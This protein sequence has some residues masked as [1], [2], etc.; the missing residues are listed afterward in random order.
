M[1]YTVTYNPNNGDN[2]FSLKVLDNHLT[3]RPEEPIKLGYDF[4]GWYTEYDEQ[5]NFL[6]H[7]VKQDI[8]L[9]AKWSA[10]KYTINLNDDGKISKLDVIYNG[11]YTLP[12]PQKQGYRFLYWVD[13]DGNEVS[14]GIYEKVKDSTL[15]A[16]YRSLYLISF[17]TNGGNQIDDYEIHQENEK[18]NELPIPKKDN[19]TFLGWYYN[20]ENVKAPLIYSY[21][22]DITLTA[23]W[24]LIDGDYEIKDIDENTT[25]V[26]AYLGIDENIEIPSIL[27]N[28]EVKKI[29]KNAFYN[30][31]IVKSI[32]IPESVTSI[33]DYAF[34][35]CSSLLSITIPK[36]V[37]SIGSYAFYDCSSLTSIEIPENVISIGKSAFN[38]C[39]SL[40]NFK[41][42]SS[43]T[44]IESA[45][46]ASCSSLSSIEIPESVTSIGFGAFIRCS[47][48]TNFKIP[49]SITK[50]ER[51]AFAFCNGLTSII[52]PESVISIE[53]DVFLRC[54]SLTIVFCE[55]SAPYDYD[56]KDIS[57]YYANEWEYVD[58]V[59]TPIN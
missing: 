16:I 31:K 47:S 24:A 14:S 57:V 27:N 25:A 5:W 22:T 8:T 13:E 52:I 7:V 1:Y 12:T 9:T 18:I 26:I 48:L 23:K 11:S 54:N 55:T 30:N 29:N 45:T 40:T 35:R 2:N 38:R 51:A 43:I 39:S 15:T 17:D 41:I 36:S 59:P 6:G 19:L 20:E 32:I 34:N 10:S 33:G 4:E 21:E 53:G 28:K 46:F 49:S 3:T 58:G 56:F 42:P 50:I 37:T 44:K